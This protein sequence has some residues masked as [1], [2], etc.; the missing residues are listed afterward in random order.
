[1]SYPRQIRTLIVEDDEKPKAF[2]DVLFSTLARENVAPPQYAFCY[3]DADKALKEHAVFHL[4]ILDL[5]LPERP[6]QP[7][8]DQLEFG[9]ALLRQCMNRNDYPI[10]GLLII[11]GQ[12]GMAGNQI[13]LDTQVRN[14]FAYGRIVTKGSTGNEEEIREAIRQIR[15]YCD[16]GVHVRDAGDLSD[17]VAAR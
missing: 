9:V 3:E 17:P 11:S 13:E 14:G 16:I 8:A 10:P 5:R 4:V 7:P 6:G 15:C 12:L 1:M 2:Y